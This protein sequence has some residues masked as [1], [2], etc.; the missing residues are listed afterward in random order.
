MKQYLDLVRD[1]IENG[2]LQ[3]N[4]TGIRTISLPG[5]MLRFDLQ[6]GFPAIT[7]RKLAFKSAIGEMVGFL[8]GV[9][10]AGEFRDLGCKVWDQ[11]ANENAQWLANPFRQ[12]HDDLGEIYGVQW[13]QWPAYKRIPLSNPAAI[14]LAKSQGFQQIAQ[15]EEDGEAFVVLYKAIDQIRQ[16]IDT[17]HNDPGSRRILFH[18]WNCAQLDEMA[19]PPCHLLYQFHPNVETREIS[20][21]L[22]IRSNDLGLGTPFNLTEGAA[23]LSLMGRLT[24]YTPRWFTYF[25]G[26]AH[27]YENHLDMLNEQL[28]REPLAAPK[29]V[30]NDRVPEFAKTGVYEPE[31]LEKIEPSDFSLEGYEHH[32]PMTAPM[33]V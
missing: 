22:Y 30:I 12:G 6:K 17:I 9:K 13:R 32:A 20:L 15:A 21:T 29:L 31:W 28:K 7:T 3:G 2:T 26:D 4:R 10:N 24:G 5:A 8:R 1:V 14:E 33:A 27:V 25:I 16:C 23:L 18:G 19:L 11:N